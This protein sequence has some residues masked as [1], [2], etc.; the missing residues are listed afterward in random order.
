MNSVDLSVWGFVK[1]FQMGRCSTVQEAS[2]YC[3]PYRDAGSKK[4]MARVAQ[5]TRAMV[6]IHGPGR[7]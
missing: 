2:K 4:T 1:T 7:S 3:A 6:C 5:R